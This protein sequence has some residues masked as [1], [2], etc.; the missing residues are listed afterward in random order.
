VAGQVVFDGIAA[1]AVEA[2]FKASRALV[3]VI[4]DCGRCGGGD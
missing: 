1:A 2:G 3:E 4:G